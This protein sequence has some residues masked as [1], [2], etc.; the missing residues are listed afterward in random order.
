VHR[1]TP[2]GGTILSRWE[3]NVK[4]RDVNQFA[5]SAFG[6]YLIVTHSSLMTIYDMGVIDLNIDFGIYSVPNNLKF[7]IDARMHGDSVDS[8]TPNGFAI[9]IEDSNITQGIF[10]I[11]N[12]RTLLSLS[13]WD[14]GVLKINESEDVEE[15][16]V[17]SINQFIP[18][19]R[20][21]DD[22]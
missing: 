7:V 6:C 4:A 10:C 5:L 15:W 1:I 2:D 11:D 16:Q 19:C 18:I 3:L 21:R 13:D 9:V 20:F 22:G 17:T 14:F 12:R 8:V